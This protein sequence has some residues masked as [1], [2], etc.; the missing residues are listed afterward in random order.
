MNHVTQPLSSVNIDIIND[1]TNKTLSRDSNYIVDVVM[2]KKFG[3]YSISKREFMITWS[4][5]G[6][7]QREKSLFWG[8]VLVQIQ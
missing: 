5:Y 8:M 3:N 2:W 4:L 1:V 6:F 7:D